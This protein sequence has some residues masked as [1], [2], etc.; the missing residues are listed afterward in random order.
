M[1]VISERSYEHAAWLLMCDIP[2]M[3]AVAEVESG[4]LGAF[5]ST[6]EPVILFERHVF[7]RLTGGRYDG[8]RVT[9]GGDHWLI[10]SPVPGGYGPSS[11]QHRKL[12]YAAA[13][14]RTAALRA[15]SWGL[16]QIM[17]LNHQNAGYAQLQRFVN[18]M[19]RSADDHLRAFAMFIRSNGLLVDALRTHDWYTFARIYNGP[20][21]RENR[22]DSKL[23]EAYNRL[24]EA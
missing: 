5:L 19:Y 16:F 18:A 21:F 12:Q 8:S 10:S 3:K 6:G 1:S 11:I 17:G 14:D 23:S 7:H 2:A 4:P 22:Y 9:S 13:M 24:K 20:K 15:C